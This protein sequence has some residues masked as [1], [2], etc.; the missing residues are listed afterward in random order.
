M[1]GKKKVGKKK[2]TEPKPRFV[3][4]DSVGDLVG[5]SLFDKPE[6][7]ELYLTDNARERDLS[8][9]EEVDIMELKFSH[10]VR[11]DYPYAVTVTRILK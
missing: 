9:G 7:A 8:S 10:R 2:G 4:V 5:D 11:I 3:I 6:D 1:A